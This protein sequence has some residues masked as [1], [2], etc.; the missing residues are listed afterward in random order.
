M[1]IIRMIRAALEL[2]NE[3]AYQES[4]K[5]AHRRLRLRIWAKGMRR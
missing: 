1:R 5:E 2:W 4:R 3:E